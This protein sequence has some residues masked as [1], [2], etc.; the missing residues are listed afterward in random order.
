MRKFFGFLK[1]RLD[2]PSGT[3]SAAEARRK[4]LQRQ[5]LWFWVTLVVLSL[6]VFSCSLTYTVVS[7]TNLGKNVE[8]SFWQVL[9]L[10]PVLLVRRKRSPYRVLRERSAMVSAGIHKSSEKYV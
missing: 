6:L 2:G 10:I 5:L 4:A 7:F 9:Y 1:G 3:A 8:V